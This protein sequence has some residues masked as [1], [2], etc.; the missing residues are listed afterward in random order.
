MERTV[1]ITRNGKS[2]SAK[3]KIDGPNFDGSLWHCDWRC[4]L[5]H[6]STKRIYGSDE[7]S[8]LY[9]C[10][11]FIGEFFQQMTKQGW[12]VTFENG[13]DNGGFDFGLK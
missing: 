5:I 1:T 7:I 3:L 13:L 9:Y 11:N 2:S 12:E 4:E 6:P 10:L 8:A